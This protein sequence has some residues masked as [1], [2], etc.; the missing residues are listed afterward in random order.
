MNDIKNPRTLSKSRFKSALECP[1]KL[2]YYGKK[3]EYANQMAENEFMMALAE[4]GFQ[5]GE[6]AKYSHPCCEDMGNCGHQ[7]QSLTYH[8]SLAETAK[9]I[10]NENVILY[11]PAVA[12]ENL[13]IRID[14]LEKNGNEVELIEVKAKSYDSK[15]GFRNKNG[16]GEF[17]ASS[18]RPYLYDV[19]FQTWVM[20]QAY[21]D[22][23][24]EPYLMMADKAATATVDGINQL[25]RVKKNENNRTVIEVTE[26]ITP[27]R[28]G[29]SVLVKVPVREYVEMIW[30]GQDID[31][32]KKEYEEYKNFFE[33]AREYAGFYERD[34]RYPV[35]VGLKCKHCEYK[36]TPDSAAKGLKSGYEECWQEKFGDDF[37]FEE[38]HVFELWNFRHTRD[39]LE[40]G[41]HFLKDL[42]Y[43][44]L[45][46]SEPKIP[47]RG[48]A[49]VDRQWL[50]VNKRTGRDMED[51]HINPELFD[52]MNEWDYPLHFIDF[53]TSMVSIPFTSGRRPYEQTAFQFSCHSLHK[54]GRME[55]REWINGEPGVFPNYEF[56]LALKKTLGNDDGTIFRY[57]NHENTVMRQIYRQ[58]ENDDEIDVF[59]DSGASNEEIMDWIDTITNWKVMDLDGK[60]YRDRGDRD[61]IDLWKCVKSYYYHPMMKGSNSIKQVLP[62]MMNVSKFLEDK[63]SQPMKFGRNLNGRVLWQKDAHGKVMD[64]YKLLEPIHD[65]IETDELYLERGEIQDGG[66]AMVAYAKLQFTQMSDSEREAII[67]A[68]LRYCE[69]D[70][71]AMVMI[72]D[73]WH[74]CYLAKN[75]KN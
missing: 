64:P 7:I 11:E 65:D 49:S 1:T 56:T 14:V 62:T 75:G 25:F 27:E 63:Y 16:I 68:L 38:P 69:M 67:Q 17:I 10:H 55:H 19:A 71:L 52:E 35:T 40:R 72:Y 18:W 2:Y 23:N 28:L 22:W 4:G 12:F 42:I 73:H 8:E 36:N 51:E 21:P 24:V 60:E 33:R 29:D 6:L 58:I 47:E 54:D 57:S 30:N 53:E 20:E 39:A 5:V 34:E 13:F 3:K 70:T 66:A 15:K 26:E 46:K 74:S 32:S 50:Q 9:Y 59:K 48:M 37:D 45:F 41:I 43:E 44:D 31:P 61:M